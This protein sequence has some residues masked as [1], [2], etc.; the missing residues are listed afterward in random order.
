MVVYSLVNEFNDFN[1]IYEIKDSL[2]FP[3][4]SFLFIYSLLFN[5][6]VRTKPTTKMAV[7]PRTIVR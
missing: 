5:S 7:V 4:S 1:E 6:F 2:L 3:L